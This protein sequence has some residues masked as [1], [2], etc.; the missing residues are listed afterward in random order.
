MGERARIGSVA[1]DFTLAGTVLTLGV[2]TRSSYTLSQFSGQP[3]ILAFYPGDESLVCTAQLCSYQSELA[4]FAEQGAQVW[5]IS[6]QNLDSHE[7]FARKEGLAFP[8]L[9]DSDRVVARAYGIDAPLI[10]V[11][12]SVFVLD[13]SGVIRWKKVALLGATFV[14]ATAISEALTKITTL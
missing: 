5:G 13:A 1:P 9:A 4:G 10:G 6:P 12:R 3:I 2:A 8:L 14:S 7:R 11:R